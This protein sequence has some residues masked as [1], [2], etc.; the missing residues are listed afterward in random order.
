MLS[1][2]SLADSEG[3]L[4]KKDLTSEGNGAPGRLLNRDCIGGDAD[5]DV[6]LWR[7]DSTTGGS[8]SFGGGA[9]IF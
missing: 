5:C 9:M 1:I 3:K 8:V 7:K 6:M 4:S 2:E